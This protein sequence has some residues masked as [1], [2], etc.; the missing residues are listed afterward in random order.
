MNE[1]KIYEFITKMYADLKSSQEKMN[2]E[3]QEGFKL[4]GNKFASMHTEMRQNFKRIDKLLSTLER[5]MVKI[6]F[7]HGQKL[8]TLFDGMPKTQ[9][10]WA[11]LKLK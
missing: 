1:E 5:N 11:V 4:V 6:E 2:T 10:N 9:R 8:A 7:E 3:M